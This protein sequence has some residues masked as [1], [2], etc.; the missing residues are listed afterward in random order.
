MSRGALKIWFALVVFHSYPA[1]AMQERKQGEVL[2]KRADCP[3]TLEGKRKYSVA[4]KASEHAPEQIPAGKSKRYFGLLVEHVVDGKKREN[5]LLT[6]YLTAYGHQTLWLATKEKKWGETRTLWLGECEVRNTAKDEGATRLRLVRANETS[7]EWARLLM[8]RADE[9]VGYER[10]VLDPQV[11]HRNSV[12]HLEQFLRENYGAW[13]LDPVGWQP[14]APL[15]EQHLDPELQAISSY[16]REERARS[17]QSTR[18]ANTN[19]D[20]RTPMSALVSAITLLTL[21]GFSARS[22][23]GAIFAMLERTQPIMSRYLLLLQNEYPDDELLRKARRTLDS[24]PRLRNT[25][26]AWTAEELSELL[27]LKEVIEFIGEADRSAVQ[28]L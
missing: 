5:L 14:W 11:A 2:L 19:H 15:A 27:H 17:G 10:S 28:I 6:P 16:F 9:D 25:L 20:I 24:L 4:Q 3:E 23:A 8:Q 7:G 26:G 13:L 1:S 21:P 12:V 18:L 22:E